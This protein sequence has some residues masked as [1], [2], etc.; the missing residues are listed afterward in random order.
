VPDTRRLV[1][2]ESPAKAS[3]IQKYLGP[4]WVVKSSVGHIRDLPSKRGEVPESKRDRFGDPIGVDVDGGYE[5]L[6]RVDDGSRRTIA[7]LKQ[8]LAEADELYLATD[9]DREGEAIAWHLLQELKPRVPVKRMVFNEITRSAIER[10]VQQTRDLDD[11]L[12]DAQETRRILDRLYG[13]PVSEVLWRKIKQGTSA[14]RVQSVATRLLVARERERIA[15]RSAEFWDVVATL[16]A[17]GGESFPARLVEIDGAR[18]AVGKDFTAAGELSEAAR[19]SVVVFDEARAHTL[20]TGLENGD[21]TVSSVESK[22]LRKRP[23]APFRTTTLQQDASRKL[24]FAPARTMAVAQGL[25]QRG[26]I[27]YMRTDSTTLS[28]D[29]VQ[30]SRAQIEAL[31]GAQFLPD[32]PRTYAGK[33][34]NAQE[35][36]EAI[37]PA[38]DSFRTPA[39]TQLSGDDFRLYELIWQ[40]TLASQMHDARGE[41]VRVRVAATA[42]SGE[43]CEFAASGT[44]ITFPGFRA[45][46]VESSEDKTEAS[47]EL[48]P[49]AE[50][51]ALQ[52]IEVAP[53]GHATK[54]PARYTEASLVSELEKREIGRPSTY[55]TIIRRVQDQ[56]YAI[57]RGTALVPTWLAFGV[58]RLLEEN[59][60]DLVDYEFTA[61]MEDVLDQISNGDEQRA[62][63]LDRFWRGGEGFPGVLRL[64]EESPGIDGKTSSSFD[65]GEGLHVRVGRHGAYLEDDDGRRGD[66]PPEADLTPDELTVDKARELIEAKAAGPRQLGEHPETGRVVVVRT[67]R[68]GPYFSEVPPED[69]EEKPRNASLLRSMHPDSVTLEDAV[70]MLSLPRVV[71]TGSDGGQITARTGRYGPFIEKVSDSGNDRRS[72]DSEE[73]IFTVTV[74]QAEQLFAQPKRRRG[75]AAAAPGRPLG[76]DP[77]TSKAIEVKSG[78]Y[79]PYVTDGEY[80]ATIPRDLDP[81]SVSLEAAAELL[82]ERRAKGPAKKSAKRPTKKK[83]TKKSTSKRTTAKKTT[84]KKTTAKEAAAKKATAKK[85]ASTSA[86]R[87]S[88]ATTTTSTSGR[89]A[90][91]R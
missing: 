29:A 14:G 87:T 84:A 83:A 70:K 89:D 61:E 12:V 78:R 49:V 9:E 56:E 5:A 1:I 28:A 25:Y 63:A 7:T 35:A 32:A 71:G 20:A 37:R 11:N 85:T 36:H 44:V 31:Y 86:T 60:A 69:S 38:G 75:Q 23:A 47:S 58:T 4:G 54:P 62:R 73:A 57:K 51:D 77:H 16:G 55:A 68:F 26:F 34:K 48:P 10:A 13:Y 82:A 74:E 22:P 19:S 33:V 27:T 42:A 64:V 41:S 39:E 66:L 59:F 91:D 8:S 79:G 72:L 3:T 67:G 30:A 18:V 52:P 88:S 65:L 21:F 45:V 24:G 15:F 43:A 50:G 76:T 6:Y 17:G 2:V 81:D 90:S 53:D 80:N 46:Y 40:R